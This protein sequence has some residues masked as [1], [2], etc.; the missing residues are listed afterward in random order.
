MADFAL[1][2]FSVGATSSIQSAGGAGRGGDVKKIVLTKS[3]DFHHGG[4]G[5]IPVFVG[6]DDSPDIP[7]SRKV[8]CSRKIDDLTIRVIWTAV[9]GA[10]VIEDLN[11]NMLYTVTAFDYTDVYGA[12]TADDVAPEV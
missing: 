3:R 1:D 11:P 7:L 4:V 2:T 8:T 5:F 6:I 12:V 10:G 9:D